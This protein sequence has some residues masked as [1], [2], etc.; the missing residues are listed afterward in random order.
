[1]KTDALN[2]VT[3]DDVPEGP[4]HQNMPMQQPKVW[5]PSEVGS[6]MAEDL[7]T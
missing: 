5:A 1:M 4:K 6:G 7:L 2:A 3:Y